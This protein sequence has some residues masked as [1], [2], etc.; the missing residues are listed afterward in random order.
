MDLVAIQA[1]TG[2]EAA[3]LGEDLVLPGFQASELRILIPQ[4]TQVTRNEAADGASSLRR[5][6]PR[7]PVDV[8][9]Y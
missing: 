8:V 3:D 7:R 6:N 2:A 9:G 5:S 4:R 1:V